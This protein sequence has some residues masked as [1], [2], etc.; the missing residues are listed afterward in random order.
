MRSADLTAAARI[1][2]A[3][4][5]QFGQHGFAT[6]L[7]AVAEAAGVSAALVI[8]HFGSKE[9]LRKACDDYIAEE[10]R[11][12]KSEA[13]RSTDPTTWFAQL[14]EIE[15]Y[16][17]MMAYLVRSMQAGGE[18]AQT[19]WRRMIEDAEEYIDEGVRAG[20]LKPSRDP[21]ARAKYLAIAG[22]GSFLLYLQMHDNPT[23]LRAVLRDYGNE[24]IL[25]SLEL[26]TEGLI[27]DRT[28]YDAFLEQAEARVD[29]GEADV[30]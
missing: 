5:E 6:G 24:M 27:A 18:L 23:D 22:G 2:D 28:M 11:S 1:R 16:A 13:M 29:Q 30:S 15:S 21:K 3:A 7:R 8:H 25:P 12:A 14:A 9:G 19:L 10:I 26:Y 4:I 20:T 17:P